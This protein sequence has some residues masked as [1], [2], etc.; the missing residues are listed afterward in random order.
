MNNDRPR[1]NEIPGW[2][3]PV[4]EVYQWAQRPRKFGGRLTPRA[5]RWYSTSGLI[6][7]PAHFGREAYYNRQLIFDYIRTVEILNRKFNFLLSEV[8]RIIKKTEGLE[9]ICR[10]IDEKTEGFIHIHPVNALASLLQEYL[11]YENN[12]IIQCEAGNDGPNLSSKQLERL[13]DLRNE[14]LKRLKG[15]SKEIESLL[16]SS[17]IKL[18]ADLFGEDE[19]APR[20][21]EAALAI[22]GS[23]DH[24]GKV[25]STVADSSDAT[26]GG[27]QDPK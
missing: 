23:D 22:G 9:K 3:I 25:N 16:S 13:E 1:K 14:M 2:A 19:E 27:E 24:A 6:P 11:E 20:A 21:T 15:N 10:G 5:I 4:S 18:E 26:A 12:E 7:D 8:R 17:I